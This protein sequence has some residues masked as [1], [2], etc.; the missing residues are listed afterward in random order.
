MFSIFL[1]C[2][3]VMFKR[4]F[5]LAAWCVQMA[6]AQVRVLEIDVVATDA[7]DGFVGINEVAT[8]NLPVPTL[9]RVKGSI[10]PGDGGHALWR[11]DGIIWSEVPKTNAAAGV[12]LE[13]LNAAIAVETARA[14][15][16]E[17]ALAA[18]VSTNTAGVSA[19]LADVIAETARAQ[20]AEAALAADV[21]T[22]A[23]AITTNSIGLSANAADIDTNEAAI[24]ANTNAI[25]TTQTALNDEIARAMVA[26]GILTDDG[27][28][29]A[30][31]LAAEVTRALAAEAELVNDLSAEVSRATTTEAAMYDDNVITLQDALSRSAHLYTFDEAS[32]DF[33]DRIGN[34]DVAIN[35]PVPPA[36]VA[37]ARFLTSRVFNGTDNF[38][39]SS[40]NTERGGRPFW[41]SV[42]VRFDSVA[43]NAGIVSSSAGVSSNDVVSGNWGWMFF[44]QGNNLVFRARRHGGTSQNDQVSVSGITANTDY[45]VTG[46]S[47]GVNMSLYLYNQDQ[48][49]EASDNASL[50]SMSS[51]VL[52]DVDFPLNIGWVPLSSLQAN[53][54]LNGELGFL[55]IGYGQVSINAID[56]INESESDDFR[57]LTDK[58]QRDLQRRLKIYGLGDSLTTEAFSATTWAELLAIQ[59]S[60]SDNYLP[61]W[62]FESSGIGGQTSTLIADRYL[63]YPISG[64]KARVFVAWFGNN[65]GITT[66]LGRDNVVNNYK[67]VF[68]RALLSG[69]E[70]IIICGVPNR[71]L[72]SAS[73]LDKD[74]RTNDIDLLNS[75]IE[76]LAATNDRIIYADLQSWFTTPANY[77]SYAL[78]ADDLTDIAA[79]IVPRGVRDTV[80]NTHLNILGNQHLTDLLF[81]L[82]N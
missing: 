24:L 61:D 43:G 56:V 5:L 21:A 44:R 42:G 70:T 58:V 36:S 48:V 63:S 32:G 39:T 1:I 9:A 49:L 22:N 50:L 20:A 35:N 11:W 10:E 73:Q 81:T 75:Q 30:V 12:K 2:F 45:I 53:N 37:N 67:R 79:N 38:G 64:I 31:N 62:T 46:R 72:V 4:C 76:A 60:T 80:S 51:G 52:D 33:L 28:D 65:D 23:G 17:A 27:A 7:A 29:N 19:N 71:T 41:F 15:A 40:A 66:K 13:D 26:E 69:A 55:S 59:Q 54:V 74:A 82:I 57:N 14:E 3:F 25:T 6:C 77:T 8:L 47:D 16:A 78:T 18:D 68:N 34:L